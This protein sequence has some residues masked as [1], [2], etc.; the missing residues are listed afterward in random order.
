MGVRLD[1]PRGVRLVLALLVAM[2]VSGGCSRLTNA[3]NDAGAWLAEQEH[4]TEVTSAKV[5]HGDLPSIFKGAVRLAATVEDDLTMAELTA[6]GAKL[7]AYQQEHA[8]TVTSLV[9][10]LSTATWTAPL[11]H[12]PDRT[13]QLADALPRLLAVDGVGALRIATESARA[14]HLG[15]VVSFTLPSADDV[16]ARASTS[17]AAAEGLEESVPC[18]VTSSDERLVVKLSGGSAVATDLVELA[19]AAL[20]DP[21]LTKLTLWPDAGAGRVT[22]TAETDS[23]ASALA[24]HALLV[25]A[26]PEPGALHV[27]HDTFWLNTNTPIPSALG[28]DL[29]RLAAIEGLARLSL[30]NYSVEV[31]GDSRTIVLPTLDALTDKDRQVH[32]WSTRDAPDVNLTGTAATLLTRWPLIEAATSVAGVRYVAWSKDRL[33]V[34]F[35]GLDPSKV[36]ALSTTLRAIGWEGPLDLSISGDINTKDRVSVDFTSTATGRAIAIDPTEGTSRSTDKE[37]ARAAATRVI[38][39]WDA[40]ARGG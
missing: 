20:A 18:T 13:R 5:V 28:E 2:L 16:V 15:R 40:A 8:D 12:V 9:A 10:D 25:P 37:K 39:D 26:V 27:H 33:T 30:T 17:C 35:D 3:A 32:V 7:S 6:L 22:A 36:R 14:D 34:Q 23:V 24:A 1:R 19:R 31:T 21:G 38:E 11:D 29:T 4:V